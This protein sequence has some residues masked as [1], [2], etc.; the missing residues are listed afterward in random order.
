MILAHY[1]LNLEP[2]LRCL[3]SSHHQNFIWKKCTLY[4]KKY[5]ICNVCVCIFSNKLDLFKA[6][7]FIIQIANIIMGLACLLGKHAL[8]YFVK[9][10]VKKN[11]DFDIL[12]LQVT[13]AKLLPVSL[14]AKARKKLIINPE[15]LLDN[16]TMGESSFVAFLHQEPMIRNLLRR[17][18]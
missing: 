14:K 9:A 11:N 8:F 3:P 16:V 12:H 4:L 5:G 7:C 13:D 2:F 10:T 15:E 1:P 6:T 18:L 17:N